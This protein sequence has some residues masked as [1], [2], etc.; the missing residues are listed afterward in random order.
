MKPFSPLYFIRENRQKSVLLIFMIMLG[1][2]IYLGGLYVTNPYDNWRV[3][4]AYYDRVTKV[5]PASDDGDLSQFKAFREEIE[6]DG[7]VLV[8]EMGSDNG[9]NWKTVM[10]FETGRYSATFRSVEDFRLFC[11]YMGIE[12]DFD[13]LKDGSLVMSE[14]F[15]Q[16]RGLGLGDIV[17][18][19][20]DASVHAPYTLDAVTDEE[21]YI[22][23]FISEEPP[24]VPELMLLG[25]GIDG[26]EL[27]DIVYEIQKR[28]KVSV[29]DVLKHRLDSQFRTFDMIYLFIVLLLSV[30]LAVTI[31]AV[32]V[33][34]YQ[35]R[36]FEIA[37]Y[38]AIGISK[39]RI[40]G[41]LAGELLWMD[42]IALG[43]GGVLF[44]PG[45]YLANNCLLYPSGLYLRYFHPMALCGLAVCN[46]LVFIPLVLGRCRQM[47]KADIC[48]Y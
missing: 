14:M 30:I 21:G 22:L 19:D 36:N 13:N 11:E 32:F 46:I 45:L 39:Y 3:P 6:A 10:G 42:V 12:C 27:Y 48:E 20:F 5:N 26:E 41:K 2:V 37:I 9:F 31:N 16:N 34:I 43:A 24:D 38:R 17:D 7:R 25:N 29:Y 28:H 33:G 4:V 47:W 15:A 8:L 23:H 18:S 44:F 1:Y 40:V 35:R